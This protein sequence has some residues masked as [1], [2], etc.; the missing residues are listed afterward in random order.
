MIWYD[1]I[2]T[3]QKMGLISS[4]SSHHIINTSL[5]FNPNSYI[6]QRGR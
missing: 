2:V 6:S 3:Y 5:L 1:E 4:C